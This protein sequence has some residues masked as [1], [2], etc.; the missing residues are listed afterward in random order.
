MNDLP[1]K[2]ITLLM[3]NAY[4]DISSCIDG[5]LGADVTLEPFLGLQC[6]AKF[7]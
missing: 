6:V 1:N 7:K 3:C 4:V 2:L 5:Y